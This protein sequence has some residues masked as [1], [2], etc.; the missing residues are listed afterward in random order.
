L[1]AVRAARARGVSVSFDCNYRAKLWEAWRGDPEKILRELVDQ[2]DLVF[3]DD[4]ALALVLSATDSAG[5]LASEAGTPRGESG[6]PPQSA[7]RFRTAAEQAL[8]AFPRLQHVA[9][10]LRTEHTVDHHQ[11]SAVLASRQ[12]F[13]STRSY[14]LEVI[15]D[16]IGTGD[17]FAAGLLHGLLIGMD[18]QRSLDFAL[19]AAVLKHS[20]PGD[21][22]PVTP[23]QVSELLAGRGFSVRR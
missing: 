23:E 20:I 17:A 5:T 8:K 11:M 10:T 18:E 21:V 6:P 13:A 9:T 19:A 3:A 1:R 14:S 4:R 22:N 16:R 15:V 2:A 7:A 12:G